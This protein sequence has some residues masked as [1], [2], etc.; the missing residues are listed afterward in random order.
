M[1]N[2]ILKT[3][4]FIICYYCLL[5]GVSG[6]EK[7]DSTKFFKNTIRTNITNPM[8]FGD[9]YKVLGYERVLFDYQTISLNVGI[10]GLPKFT[11]IDS[12]TLALQGD[13]NDKG[14]TFAM[15]YRFY[16]K[17]ENKHAAP[18]G[19]YI[20][21]YYS[22]IN[23]N[24]VNTWA[25]N[26]DS[27]TGDLKTDMDLKMNLVGLQLGYQFIIK[28]RLAI[29]L[30]LAGPGIW[31]YNL[32]TSISTTLSDE[33]AAQI[34]DKLNEVLAS[35]FPGHELAINPGKYEKKGSVRASSPGYRMMINLGFRF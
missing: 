33:D 2:I 19:V 13:S 12:D 22:Y 17:N 25:L 29:D 6:H 28:K 7:S 10:M 18:R 3:L 14:F 8:I 20:G 31:F 5:L 21:P 32:E 9:Q 11:S 16:L 26:L 4:L 34:F 30:V 35:K 15:D 23:F 24:R 27:F 1:K